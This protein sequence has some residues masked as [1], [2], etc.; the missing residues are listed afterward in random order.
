MKPLKKRQISY[1]S[2]RGPWHYSFY[3]FFCVLVLLSHCAMGS[4]VI[5]I[6]P[7]HFHLFFFLAGVAVCLDFMSSPEPLAHGELL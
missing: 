2:V 4:Y 6:F 1:Q 5:M 7:P 3:M